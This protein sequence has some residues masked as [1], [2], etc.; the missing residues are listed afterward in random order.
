[1]SQVAQRRRR[2]GD[3]DFQEVLP[4]NLEQDFDLL[5]GNQDDNIGQAILIDIVD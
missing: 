4:D 3:V 1:M 2:A 5:V